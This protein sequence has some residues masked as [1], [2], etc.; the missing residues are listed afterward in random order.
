MD[1]PDLY[2]PKI[3]RSYAELAAHYG[4]LADPA[5]ALKPRGKARVERPLP[6]EPFALATWARAKIGPDIHAQVEKVLYSVP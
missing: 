5:R 2:Y 1:K 4:C 6:A 3:N